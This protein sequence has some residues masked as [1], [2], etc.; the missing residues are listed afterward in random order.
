M[1]VTLA[2]TITAPASVSVWPQY[3]FLV[4]NQQ[5]GLASELSQQ[6]GTRVSLCSVPPAEWDVITA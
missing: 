1:N 3:P 4:R 5:L 6:Y 2:E